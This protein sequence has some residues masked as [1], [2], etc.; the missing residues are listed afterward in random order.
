[1][2]KPLI[3][4]LLFQAFA[5]P[6][7]TAVPNP[8]QVTVVPQKQKKDYD[9]LWA[10]FVKAR[11]KDDPKIVNDAEKLLKKTPTLSALIVLEAYIDLYNNRV[12]AAEAR[13]ERVLGHDPK[14]RIALS[15]L[16]EFAFSRENYPRASAL[17]TRLL[18]A[19]PSRTDVETKRQKA[20]LLATEALIQAASRA[21]M[22][23]RPV[24]AEAMYVQALAIAPRE[25]SLHGRL[26]DLYARQKM[27]GKAVDEFKKE[28]EFGGLPEDVDRRL[29]EA[30]ANDGKTDEAREIL[31]NLKKSGAR[32][33]GLDARLEELEDIGRWGKD[34]PVFRT[35]QAAPEV[36]REQLSAMIVRYFPQVADFRGTP[37]VVTDIQDSW[38]RP[39]IQ[40][41]MG[42]GLVEPFSNHTFQPL[43][44]V[45]RG[46]VAKAMARLARL[47]MVPAPAAPAIPVTDVGAS[48]ALFRDVQQVL[49]FGLMSLD[50]SDS[51]NVSARISGEQAVG[52]FVKLLELSRRILD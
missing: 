34:L 20:L 44:P 2:L 4:A 8:A 28:K 13:F 7:R 15:Y 24:Q 18:E 37:Q 45:T 23:N 16:A 42:V 48:N 51:F 9:K 39:E 52:A 41:V 38:A 25:P 32:D 3:I 36:T 17:Y 1:M 46:D 14:N 47:L 5:M 12:P 6:P 22:E 43:A 50:D 10:R 49:G 21:E 26:G 30:L 31:E 35:I 29:A 33:A 11:D 40:T 19:D 27:Y